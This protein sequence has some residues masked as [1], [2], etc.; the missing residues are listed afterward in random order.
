MQSSRERFWPDATSRRSRLFLA[1]STVASRRSWYGWFAFVPK[2][3]ETRLREMES[4][5]V[6]RDELAQA[7]PL[8]SV[9][10]TGWGE[11]QSGKVRDIYSF[12]DKR[13][14]ITTDRVSAF[15]RV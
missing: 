11:K 9:D 5:M 7:V 1:A 3:R 10:L 8:R 4:V 12:E 2:W 13:I 15:D 14:L 6:N